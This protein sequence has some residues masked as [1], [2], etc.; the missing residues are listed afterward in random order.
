MAD[1]LLPTK[2]VTIDGYTYQFTMLEADVGLELWPIL[3][4]VLAKGLEGLSDFDNLNEAAMLKVF[5]NAVKA[6]DGPTFKLFVEVL[7]KSCLLQ[8]GANMPAM[9]GML[10]NIHFAGRYVALTH[11][12]LQGLLFNFGSFLGGT[13]LASVIESAR[14]AA[15]GLMS[16]PASTGSSGES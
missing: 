13:S 16:R 5:T 14:A 6:F 10:F 15:S 12:M 11:W 1:T 4:N 2:P 8:Q 7:K 9:D 3:L